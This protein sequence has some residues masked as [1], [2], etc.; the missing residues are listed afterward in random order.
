[1]SWNTWRKRWGNLG[2]LSTCFCTSISKILKPVQGLPILIMKG[3]KSSI[4]FFSYG[5]FFSPLEA[6]IFSSKGCWIACQLITICIGRRID[7]R[8]R[9]RITFSLTPLSGNEYNYGLL[10]SQSLSKTCSLFWLHVLFLCQEAQCGYVIIVMALFWCTEAL[11]LAVTA[12][13]PVLLFPLMNIMD[14]TEV[15]NLTLYMFACVLVGQLVWGLFLWWFSEWEEQMALLVH[16]SHLS[17][18]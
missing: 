15:R 1:M 3:S 4:C 16:S 2:L 12:L 10:L 9:Q 18:P 8:G 17:S 7:R 13:L 14:S 6:P 5:S 11:P